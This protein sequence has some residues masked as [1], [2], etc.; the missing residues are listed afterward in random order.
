MSSPFGEDPAMKPSMVSISQLFR[1]YFP[2]I[3]RQLNFGF[4]LDFPSIFPL[5]AAAEVFHQLDD[6]TIFTGKPTIYL[7]VKTPTGFPVFRFSLFFTNPMIPWVFLQKTGR[8]TAIS[9]GSSHRSHW[10][11]HR[12]GERCGLLQ[13]PGLCPGGAK[14]VDETWTPGGFW[15]T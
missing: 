1:Q 15:A 8:F 5:D 9:P 12:L 11:S 10:W 13:W 2:G 7:M 3:S 14:N 4:S 6:G